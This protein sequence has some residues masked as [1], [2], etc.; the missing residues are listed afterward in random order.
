MLLLFAVVKGRLAL[1]DIFDMNLFWNNTVGR[2]IYD[3]FSKSHIL[4]LCFILGLIFLMF[5]NKERL[6]E[7]NTRVKIGR[8]LAFILFLQSFFLHFWYIERGV[9]TIQESLPLYLCR[10]T[11]ILC[12]F[13]ILKESYSI[14]QVVYFWGLGGASQ[15]LL[16]PD[17]GGF[18][19]PHWMFIEFFVGHGAILIATF[20]MIIAYEYKPTLKSLKKTFHWSYIYLAFVGIFNYI[21]DGNYSYLR[22]KPLASSVLDYFP[23]YPYY[24]PILVAGMFLI[25][26][27]IYIPYYIHDLKRKKL[28][29]VI[30]A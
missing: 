23:P 17:T 19:F 20:F 29:N 6:R 9:F 12:I 5:S 7:P 14:F 28:D 21:V 3:S 26:T 30:K 16:F 8:V 1:C 25:F 27:L 22:S 4:T 15:A 11:V 18:L 2:G 13:M 10:I 24:I